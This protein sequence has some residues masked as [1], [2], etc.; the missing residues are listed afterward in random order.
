MYKKSKRHVFL[1]LHMLVHITIWTRVHGIIIV[2]TVKEV[3]IQIVV[4]NVYLMCTL[5][6]K[7]MIYIQINIVFNFVTNFLAP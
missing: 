3:D 4:Y 1:G 5:N 2:Q 7:Y 6:F